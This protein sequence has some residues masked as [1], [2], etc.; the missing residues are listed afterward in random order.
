MGGRAGMSGPSRG[1]SR[2]GL[3]SDL[4]QVRKRSKSSREEGPMAV[5]GLRLGED[6]D[7]LGMVILVHLPHSWGQSRCTPLQS[8]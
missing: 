8:D 3:A 6:S 1:Q 7:Y 2:A 5:W 4:C